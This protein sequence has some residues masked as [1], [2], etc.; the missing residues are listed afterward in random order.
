MRI[1]SLMIK[2]KSQWSA[3]PSTSSGVTNRLRRESSSSQLARTRM[4]K[5]ETVWLLWRDTNHLIDCSRWGYSRVRENYRRNWI[6]KARMMKRGTQSILTPTI[7]YLTEKNSLIIRP[8]FS[9]Q[10]FLTTKEMVKSASSGA[11]FRLNWLHQ[12]PKKRSV[13]SNLSKFQEIWFR[14]SSL[15]RWINFQLTLKTQPTSTPSSTSSSPRANL[16]NL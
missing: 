4:K 6:R 8:S 10:W 2:S 11:S 12:F 7:W 16:M 5:I 1:Q 9:T 15:N 3:I 13:L 14:R